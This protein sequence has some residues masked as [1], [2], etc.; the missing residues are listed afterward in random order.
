MSLCVTIRASEPRLRQAGEIMANVAAAILGV[1]DMQVFVSRGP[2]GQAAACETF[3]RMARYVATTGADWWLQLEDDQTIEPAFAEHFGRVLEV[4]EET[5][6][7]MLYLSNRRVPHG[8]ARISRGLLCYEL[9]DVVRGAHGLLI[10]GPF[11]RSISSL[12]DTRALFPQDGII[13][14]AI[15]HSRMPVL[16]IASPVLMRHVGKPS[17]LG[18]DDPEAIEPQNSYA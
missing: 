15:R 5:Q 6:A 1:F 13:W 14:E 2:L 7:A 17:L 16:Q 8:M 12:A 9:P 11:S 3:R 10:R 18:H 4:A